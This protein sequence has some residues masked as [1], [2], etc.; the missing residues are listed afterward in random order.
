MRA[1]LWAIIFREK[2]LNEIGTMEQI[3]ENRILPSF[4]NL[5][6]EAD[7]ISSTTA[8][9]LKQYANEFSDEETIAQEAYFTGVDYYGRMD[10]AKQGIINMFAASFYHLFEQ[11]IFEILRYELLDEKEID[12][13][14]LYTICEAYGR[15]KNI[16]IDLENIV[17]FSKIYYEL[18]LICNTVKHSEG[19]SA[20]ELKKIKPEFFETLF[21]RQHPE[22]KM[23][24][25]KLVTK[26]LF[27]EGLYLTL[28]DLKIYIERI[29][30]FWNEMAI[31]L[32]KLSFANHTLSN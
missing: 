29:K 18:R 24:G 30:S 16:G 8:E 22:T 20:C 25:K 4:Q 14:K 6:Q 17:S 12:N 19:R 31:I 15:F 21:T 13:D 7:Q 3:L 10:S 5:E 11:Q 28:V 32:D 1:K 26:P 2:F 9:K 27:G 23:K